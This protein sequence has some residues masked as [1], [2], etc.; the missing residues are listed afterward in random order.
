M[1]VSRHRLDWFPVY[2]KIVS[3]YM[4]I[5]I[6]SYTDLLTILYYHYKYKYTYKSIRN[7]R[8][9]LTQKQMNVSRH[10]LDWFPVYIKMVPV[11]MSIH[12]LSSFIKKKIPNLVIPI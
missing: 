11:Y 6:L 2:N 3:V 5:H 12:I 9:F 8:L 7:E 4:S 10:R 1:N